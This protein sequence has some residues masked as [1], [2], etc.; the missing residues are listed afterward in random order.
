[1]P[2]PTS[3]EM[4]KIPPNDVD[5]MPPFNDINAADLEA[6]PNIQIPL[7]TPPQSQHSQHQSDEDDYSDAPLV[8]SQQQQRRHPRGGRKPQQLRNP[9][10][11]LQSVSEIEI[12]TTSCCETQHEQEEELETNEEYVQDAPTSP[13]LAPPGDQNNFND[14]D[15]GALSKAR[16]SR[17]KE[18]RKK[19]PRPPARPSRSTGVSSFSIERPRGG[20][21]KPPIA[22]SIERPN[23]KAQSGS[24]PQRGNNNRRH[25]KEQESDSEDS[26]EG[27][28]A[29]GTAEEEQ[30][31][32]VQIRL[33]INLELEILFKAKIKGDVTITFLE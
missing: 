28:A 27:D 20:G 25:G 4:N 11:R 14:Y 9:P 21:R 19:Q 12:P 10:Q 1:M 18:K 8:D 15:A 31:K 7:S 30:R 17:S 13:L 32:P 6:Q 33:D 16:D 29:Q 23:E 5:E 24:K 2:P 26:A 22:V 3:P